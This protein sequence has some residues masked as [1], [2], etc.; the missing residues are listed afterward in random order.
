MHSLKTFLK[1]E[2]VLIVSASLALVS[3][4]VIPPDKH[5]FAYINPAVLILLF[6]LMAVVTGFRKMGVFFYISSEIIKKTN[7]SRIISLALVLLC[8]FSAMLVTNDV[9]LLTFVPLTIELFKHTYKKKLIFIIVM[10]TIASNLGSMVTPIGNPQNLFLYAYYHMNMSSFL[11]IMLPLGLVSL[12]LVTAVTAFVKNDT[13][14]A[15]LSGPPIT[16]HKKGT[17]FCALLFLVCLLTVFHVISN[18]IC[19][20]VIIVG[21]AILDRTIFRNV[22]YSL[23]LTFVCFFIFVGNIGRIDAVKIAITSLLHGRELLVSALICQGISNVPAAIMLAPFTKHT[24]ALI[25]GVNIGGLGTLVASLASLIS[26]KLYAKTPDAKIG[27]YIGVFSV[28]NFAFL[29]VFLVLGS[30]L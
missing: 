13:L 21:V 10:E 30:M 25:K 28:I 17:I 2:I 12:L 5:Y 9:A 14:R 23:L 1:N 15:H 7:K 22:D 3:M 27:L 18:V 24:A 29:A 8:F 16:F 20:F 6:C 11:K 19:L 26:F 4:V